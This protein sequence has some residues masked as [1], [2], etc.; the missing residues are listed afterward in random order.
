MLDG[1]EWWQFW[2]ILR[3][4]ETNLLAGSPMTVDR[5]DLPPAETFLSRE[6]YLRPEIANKQ[7]RVALLQSTLFVGVQSHFRTSSTKSSIKSEGCLAQT[8][9]VKVTGNLR[10][11]L[12]QA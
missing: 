6:I 11:A 3:I 5:I 12:L 7:H 10:P 2:L 1:V 8:D 4:R 9:A